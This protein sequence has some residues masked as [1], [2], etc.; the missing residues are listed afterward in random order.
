M[1]L[2]TNDSRFHTWRAFLFFTQNENTRV[3]ILEGSKSMVLE[4]ER[5]N[6]LNIYI[7]INVFLKTGERKTYFSTRVKDHEFKDHGTLDSISAD[8]DRIH[9]L[10]HPLSNLTCSFD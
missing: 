1:F 10:G 7:Y 5:K 4:I 8:R 6:K 2:Y 9:T 3:V